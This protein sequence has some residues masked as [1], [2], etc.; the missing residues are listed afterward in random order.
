[1][2]Y[3]GSYYQCNKCKYIIDYSDS[4]CLN[5]GSQDETEL[6]PKEVKQIVNKLL[7][8]KDF[9]KQFQ[10]YVLIEMLKKHDDY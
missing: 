4:H 2:E 8:I 1:M 6:N 10:G 3:T 5:C 9:E 7:I